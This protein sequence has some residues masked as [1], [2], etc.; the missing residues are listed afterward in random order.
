MLLLR[1]VH[2]GAQLVGCGPERFMMY[3]IMRSSVL[4]KF[5]IC[6]FH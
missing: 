1:I 4:R 2:V 5:W 3:C 6:S